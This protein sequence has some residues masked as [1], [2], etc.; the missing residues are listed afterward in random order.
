MVEVRLAIWSVLSA[1]SCNRQGTN[2]GIDRI[3]NVG[4]PRRLGL[5]GS[6]CGHLCVPMSGLGLSRCPVTAICSRYA[7][8]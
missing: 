1:P 6:R 8:D 7:A 2:A 5:S 4:G 3:C